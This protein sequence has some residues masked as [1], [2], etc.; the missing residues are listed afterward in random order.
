MTGAVSLLNGI[1]VSLFGS[2]LAASFCGALS[3]PKKRRIFWCCMVLIP[4][5]QGGAC[6]IWEMELLRK[7]YPLMVHLPL[8]LIL[9]GL[10]RRPLWAL[11]S[12]LFAYLCCQLRRWFALLTVLLLDGGPMLQDG[13]ELL[14]T[15]PLLWLLLRFVSPAV[16]RLA[17]YPTMTQIQ[18]GLIPAVYY[19]FDY[20]TVVYTDLL[21]GG[22]PV[23][24]EFMPFVC[25]AAYVVFLLHLSREEERRVRLQQA[26]DVLALQL[27]HSMREIAALRESQ[28]QTR[29]Y[30]H[31]LR[32]H[33][34]YVA[35]CIEHGQTMQAQDYI[36]GISEEIEAQKIR[37]Y[38]ENESA[39]LILS[40]YAGR[41]DR[42]G[43]E[44]KVQG[45]LPP[46]LLVS[47]SDLCVL[48]SNA[49][50]NA[51]YACRPLAAKGQAC[52]IDVQMYEQQRKIFLQITNPCGEE[53][54]LEQGI[55]VTDRP[56]HG[57]G[58]KSICA[59]TEKYGG[60]YSFLIRDQH[61]ILRVSI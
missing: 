61:F 39:N 27:S 51:L 3:D 22:S 12:V 53:V 31:D 57:T 29:R 56:G 20:V 50:E 32:H 37:Q 58:V 7:L 45:A 2:I 8:T 14:L 54:R 5:L 25:C 55:P 1:A 19:L 23:V 44:L 52:T 21:A 36:S 35:S 46:F 42:E 48:L 34:Q 30:R 10:V 9:W 40:A 17:E 28:D 16:G 18:F 15:L 60:V 24:L 33:L 11:I 47:D 6:M 26:K 41:A 59:I 4:L 49:L 38:C 13:I 43:I